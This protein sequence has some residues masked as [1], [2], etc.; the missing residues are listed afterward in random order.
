MT[1]P[2]SLR[3]RVF[4]EQHRIEAAVAVLQDG[5][6]TV[7]NGTT[8][9]AVSLNVAVLLDRYRWAHV[10][11]RHLSAKA[12]TSEDFGRLL[13]VQDEMAMCRC[14]LAAA[15]RLDLIGGA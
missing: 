5:E 14:Q 15:G 6:S 7:I 10:R 3:E 12:T 9:T 2:D 4:A 8:V 11:C 13:R 1:T